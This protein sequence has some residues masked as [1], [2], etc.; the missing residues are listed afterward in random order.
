MKFKALTCIVAMT[1]FAASAI[2]VR[3]AA[4]EKQE[5]KEGHHRYKLIDL[6]T[7]GGPNSSLS[8]PGL[9][10]LNNR[11]TFAIFA[12]TSTSN[13][14]VG[15]FIPFNAPDCFVEHPAVLQNG[16]LTALDVLPGGTNSQTDAISASGLIVGWS[17]NGLIDPLT[18]LPEGDA[19]LWERG[20]VINLGTVPG[21]T[22]SLATEVN[23]RGEVVGFSNND[24]PDPFSM[25]GFPTQTRA[26]LWQKGMIQDL[27]T[28]GGPDALAEVVNERGQIAGPAYTNSTPNP[29]TGIP[30]QDPFLWQNGT[31]TDLGTLGG[32]I[33]FPNWLNSRGQVVGTSNLAGD[34]THHG[35]L[36]DR[37]TLTDLGTLGGD[38]SEANWISDSGFVVGRADV[39]GS[40]SHHAFLWKN[41]VMTDLGVVDSFPCSTAFSVNSN[42]QVVG[43]TGICGQGGGPSFFSEHG[44]PMVDVNTLVLP[45]SDIEVVDAFQINDRGEIAG[46]G[47][48]PNGDIHAVLLVPASP[49]EIAAA[50]AAPNHV[51]P[52]PAAAGRPRPATSTGAWSATPW[53]RGLTRSRR[54]P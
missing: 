4:Q 22:E 21:G 31:M 49:A 1:L 19:V 24:V 8:G 5:H 13:P 32:T 28:L 50:A 20:K 51:A 48:L 27:G 52:R 3:L 26:F 9:Q 14:N 7:L 40:Q 30:T 43:E 39:P 34:T 6:G 46:G 17:E 29:S 35:F 53:L 2:P 54:L 18:G 38:D 33:G 44:G 42:G 11:G 25:T 45:G 10:T 16:T 15:C 41:G 36:W 23:S 12:N 37:G 47:L